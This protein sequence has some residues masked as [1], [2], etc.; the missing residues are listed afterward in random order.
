MYMF[1][2]VYIQREEEKKV[3]L[4]LICIYKKYSL[5]ICARGTEY[6]VYACNYFG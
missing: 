6:C 3:T 2:Y 5:Y 4:H 1:H